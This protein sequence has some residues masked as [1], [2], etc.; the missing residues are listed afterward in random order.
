MADSKLENK[1]NFPKRDPAHLEKL[2]RD[3]ERAERFAR[4]VEARFPGG[5]EQARAE[6]RA[7]KL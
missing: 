3:T 1:Y 7:G 2:R 4:A 5:P 6:M